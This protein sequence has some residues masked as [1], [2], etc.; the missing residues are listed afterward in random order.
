[1]TATYPANASRGASCDDEGAAAAFGIAKGLYL[2]ATP[3]FAIMALVTAASGGSD[4]ICAAAP[5]A[6]SFS[7]MALMYVLMSAF[8]L[9]PWLKLIASRRSGVRRA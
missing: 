1:M 3:T 6:S 7:G 9:P 4:V 2:A 8:H 5:D